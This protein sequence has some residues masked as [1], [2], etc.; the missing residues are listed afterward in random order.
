MQTMIFKESKEALE[1]LGRQ[2]RT[3]RLERNDRQSDFA[4]RLGVS[5]PTLRKLEQGDATAAIGTW[6][7][8]FWLLG[9]LDNLIKALSPRTS[10][11]DQWERQNKPQTRKRASK[12]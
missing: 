1:K 8:A 6:I 5:I 4:A 12:K 3:L 7:D 9:R 2:L 11:F 10:L